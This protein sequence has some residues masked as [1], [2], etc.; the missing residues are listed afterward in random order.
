MRQIADLQR[1]ALNGLVKFQIALAA[2][3][4]VPALSL[5]Y[6]QGWLFWFVLLAASWWVT[7]YFLRHDPALVA[8]RIKAGPSAEQQPRQKL[9]QA[10]AAVTMCAT[11]IVSALDHGRGWSRVSP[12]LVISGDVLVVVGYALI[13]FV[14]RENSFASAAIEVHAEQK[15]VETGP[16]AWVRHPMYSGALIGLVGTPVALGS[17]WGLLA[18][19][20]LAAVIVWRLLDEERYLAGNLAGYADYRRKVRRRLV[21]GVW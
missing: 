5:N 21:P 1:Q 11:I 12:A 16:Y 13:F 18:V 7:L 17:W 20:A 19:G 15:V 8:R 6:W 10:L 14:F 9:I 4:F 3:I 2:M